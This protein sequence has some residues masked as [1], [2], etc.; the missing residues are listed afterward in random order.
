MK[1]RTSAHDAGWAQISDNIQAQQMQQKWA[2]INASWSP[3]RLAADREADKVMKTVKSVF[4][5]TPEKKVRRRADPYSLER[6]FPLNRMRLH[7]NVEGPGGQLNALLTGADPM[8]APR[9]VYGPPGKGRGPDTPVLS[10]AR[11]ASMIGG[12][13]RSAG[14][15]KGALD[16][17]SSKALGATAW[18]AGERSGRWVE[19]AIGGGELVDPKMIGPLRQGDARGV[20]TTMTEREMSKKFGVLASQGETAVVPRRGLLT[21]P[22]P[23]P[24]G[25][26]EPLND[27]LTMKYVPGTAKHNRWG[28]GLNPERFFGRGAMGHM[29][30]IGHNIRRDMGLFTLGA[31]GGLGWGGLAFGALMYGSVLGESSDN[32]LSPT[33]GVA[34]GL[35][36]ATGG[37]VGFDIGMGFG[38]AASMVAA[39]LLGPLAP[40]IG[41]IVGGLGGTMLGEMAAD[42]PWG[43][44]EMGREATIPFNTPFLDSARA[45][46]MRQRSMEMIYRSQ[47]NARSALSM[48]A[49]AYH[50]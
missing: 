17:W 20:A 25:V 50:M 44:A 16:G 29:G 34:R 1:V 38:A 33:E 9:S 46:T 4:T 27:T 2:N 3:E 47:M 48:E 40:V 12:M 24:Y 23:L 45:Q 18:M 43:L 37:V 49:H 31:T 13:K 11:Q 8:P 19:T 5:E 10:T 14:A 39:P 15:I 30:R 22:S 21:D 28:A 36:R 7:R 6:N 26:Q 41:T 42:M 35:A 32:V